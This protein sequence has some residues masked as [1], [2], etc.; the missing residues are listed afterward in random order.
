[1]GCSEEPNHAP[2]NKAFQ[3]DISLFEWYNQADQAN[4]LRRFLTAMQGT[5]RF[6]I[7]DG[8]SKGFRA[9]F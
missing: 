5:D 7:D 3:V 2:F 6:Q 9:F 8:L 4:Q 1:M